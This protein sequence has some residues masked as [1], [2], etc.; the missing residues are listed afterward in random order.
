MNMA[1]NV[2][3]YGRGGKCICMFGYTYAGIRV[4][5]TGSPTVCMSY[6]VLPIQTNST[7][8]SPSRSKS[9]VTPPQLRP[10]QR[11]RSVR[12]PKI[13]TTQNGASIRAV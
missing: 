9:G 5:T 10:P 3:E 6:V 8:A 7:P 13:L 12:R 4:K 11:T 1:I 2:Y